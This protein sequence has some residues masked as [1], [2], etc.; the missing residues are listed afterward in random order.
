[1]LG[2]D[3]VQN[4]LGDARIPPHDLFVGLKGAVSGQEIVGITKG[5]ELFVTDMTRDLLFIAFGDAQA[6]PKPEAAVDRVRV[7]VE[8]G[9]ELSVPGLYFTGSVILRLPAFTQGEVMDYSADN[10]T[11]VDVISPGTSRA[12]GDHRSNFPGRQ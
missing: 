3:R 4:L 6:V 11:R 8:E 10:F 9:V 12:C 2:H 5:Q 1:M 7:G